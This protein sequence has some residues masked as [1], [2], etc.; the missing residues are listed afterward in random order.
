MTAIQFNTIFSSFSVNDLDKA[1]DFY[2][3][4]LGLDVTKE[5][6]GVLSVRA[7]AGLQAVIE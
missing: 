3:K 1:Y 2:T 6:M 5:N 4:T 7:T